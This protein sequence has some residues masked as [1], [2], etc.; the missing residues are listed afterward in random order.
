MRPLGHGWITPQQS[1]FRK[2]KR[3]KGMEQLVSHHVWCP[4]RWQDMTCNCPRGHSAGRMLPTLFAH[5]TPDGSVHHAFPSMSWSPLMTS[6][7]VGSTFHVILSTAFRTTFLN[8][9]FCSSYL[10]PSGPASSGIFVLPVRRLSLSPF[11]FSKSALCLDND[12]VCLLSS[13]FSL[14]PCQT[15]G[16][17]RKI[18]AVSA[19]TRAR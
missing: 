9:G 11:S 13:S 14:L 19:D 3:G 8:I 17:A 7:L 16:A 1:S 18:Y 15:R 12:Q 10:D 6:S 4:R 5:S 2:R